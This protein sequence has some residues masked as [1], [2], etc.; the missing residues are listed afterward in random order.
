MTKMTPAMSPTTKVTFQAM[1]RWP[2]KIL[3]NTQVK[4]GAEKM[5]VSASPMGISPRLMKVAMVMM[6]PKTPCKMSDPE[7]FQF[8]PS[9]QN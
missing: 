5:R 4:T 6:P 2:R 7:V 1:S 3:L 9:G 8:M